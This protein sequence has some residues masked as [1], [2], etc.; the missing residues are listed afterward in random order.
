LD[1]SKHPSQDLSGN[2]RS[3]FELELLLE[4]CYEFVFDAKQGGDDVSDQEA[5]ETL[6]HTNLDGVSV[7]ASTAQSELDL[8]TTLLTAHRGRMTLEFGSDDDT[9][10]REEIAAIS[11]LAVETIRLAGFAEGDDRLPQQRPGVAR[12]ADVKRW[13]IHKN[14]Y[15]ELKKLPPVV[16]RPVSPAESTRELIETFRAQAYR[17]LSQSG[18]IHELLSDPSDQAALSRFWETKSFDPVHLGWITPENAIEI[19][20]H[21][22]IEARWLFENLDRLGSEERRSILASRIAD[23]LE[24]EPMVQ[25]P[26][27]QGVSRELMRKLFADNPLIE[28]HPAQKGPNKK[29]DGY[30]VK[31]GPAF[32]HQHDGKSQFLWLPESVPLPGSIPAQHYPAVAANQ[33]VARHSGLVKFPELGRQAVKKV[34][35]KN[36]DML[37][38]IVG[39]LL[40]SQDEI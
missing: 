19:G 15:M 34:Q 18:Q 22:Q 5:L 27:A 29:L 26:A 40:G 4:R 24:D 30:R 39:M 6:I 11:G 2:V 32:A 17:H 10:N 7:L 8:L 9:L 36:S 16:L 21:L 35:V 28:R 37:N 12:P 33:S 1:L 3:Q 23:G 38:E 14:R 25:A 13:L 31:G 20:R